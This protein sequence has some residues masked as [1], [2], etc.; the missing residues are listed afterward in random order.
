M[1]ADGFLRCVSQSRMD[2]SGRGLGD[3]GNGGRG[4]YFCPL[5]SPG[6]YLFL[7][8]FGRPSGVPGWGVCAG[9]WLGYFRGRR[10]RAAEGCLIMAKTL[11]SLLTMYT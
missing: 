2:T 11:L 9:G 5:G 10:R 1:S 7:W 6:V 8:V 4:L 3:R